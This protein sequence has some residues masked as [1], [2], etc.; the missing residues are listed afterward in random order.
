MTT[1]TIKVK[2]VA[3]GL[4]ARMNR[5]DLASGDSADWSDSGS[6]FGVG[7]FFWDMFLSAGADRHVGSVRFEDAQ[8][9]SALPG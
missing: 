4:G 7:L 3:R 5:L 8:T 2:T 1:S 9:P 6:R